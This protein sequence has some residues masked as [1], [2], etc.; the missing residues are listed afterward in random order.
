VRDH[1]GAGE[2]LLVALHFGAEPRTVDLS[3]AGAGAAEL[4]LSTELDRDGEVDLAA[5]ELRPREGVVVA[6][7]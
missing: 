1:E 4:L 7:G 6:L 3:A 2:P 5:L